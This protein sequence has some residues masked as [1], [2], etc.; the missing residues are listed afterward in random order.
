MHQPLAV[1]PRGHAALL[2]QIDRALLQHAG[3]DAAFHIGAVPPLQHDAVDPGTVQ[4]L[5]QQ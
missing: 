4:E 3:P 1:Q 2:Q 5:G